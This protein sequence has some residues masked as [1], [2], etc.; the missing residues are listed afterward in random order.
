MKYLQPNKDKSYI[1]YNLTAQINK[2]LQN[3][4]GIEKELF[5]TIYRNLEHKMYPYLSFISRQL[6]NQ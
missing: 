3:N 5:F 1:L 2:K 4:F 6:E